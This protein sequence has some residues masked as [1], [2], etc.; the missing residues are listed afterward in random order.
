MTEIRKYRCPDGGVPFDRWIAKLRDGRA[1]ARVLVQLDCLK[2]GLLGDWKPV[3]G[4]VF[5][6]R[7]FEGKG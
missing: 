2:L 4:G 1:K 7:I 5:E 6:L 3:G